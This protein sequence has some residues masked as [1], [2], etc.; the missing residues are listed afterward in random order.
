MAKKRNPSMGGLEMPENLDVNQEL[1]NQLLNNRFHKGSADITNQVNML[2]MSSF[3]T[4]ST[5][6]DGI[7]K[8]ENLS[9]ARARAKREED[10]DFMKSIAK[11]PTMIRRTI[12]NDTSKKIKIGSRYVSLKKICI[13]ALIIVAVLAL[14]AF[15]VP[16]VFVTDTSDIKVSADNIFAFDTINELRV[17][18]ADKYSMEDNEALKSEKYENYREVFLSFKVYNMSFFQTRVPQ[19]ELASGSTSV[20]KIVYAGND[21][22]HATI[23]PFSKGKVTVKVLVNVE[24]MDDEAFRKL[25]RGL[26]FKTVDMD[27]KVTK[28]AFC[29]TIPAY[30]FVS[31]DVSLSLTPT[32]D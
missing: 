23:Q 6:Y 22:P 10:L 21:N 4:A 19:F 12:D 16:P 28:S 3:A 7:E 9:N 26:V 30:L 27:R 14:V 20:D 13:N 11:K 25:V 32:P 1:G 24:G 18:Y 31:D 8:I 2:D 29:P 5:K 17:E 15:F